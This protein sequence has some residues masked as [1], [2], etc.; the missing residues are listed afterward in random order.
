[1]GKLR[2]MEL[3]QRS[4][5]L[6]ISFVVELVARSMQAANFHKVVCNLVTKC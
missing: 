2:H 1:M 5:L 3:Y 4:R 6:L